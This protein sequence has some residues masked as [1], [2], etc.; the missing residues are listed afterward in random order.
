TKDLLGL[1]EAA[2]SENR[3]SEKRA[4]RRHSDA[5]LCLKRDLLSALEE[6]QGNVS[7]VARAMGKKRMQIHR[8]LRRFELEPGTFRVP[9][10]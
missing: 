8:W 4:L 10:Q 2:R 1:E 5:D 6:H 3:S 9:R 7:R